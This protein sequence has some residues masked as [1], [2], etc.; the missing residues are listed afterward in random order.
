MC[1][2]VLAFSA[3]YGDEEEEEEEKEE[4][5]EEEEEEEE[6]T[7]VFNAV[8]AADHRERAVLHHRL[9]V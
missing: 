1:I 5:E 7:R 2:S 6:H 4:K 8:G 9:H 3:S